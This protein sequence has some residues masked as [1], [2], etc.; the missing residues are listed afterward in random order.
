[1]MR[2]LLTGHL[3]GHHVRL[4]H[5]RI[6]DFKDLLC[7]HPGRACLRHCPLLLDVGIDPGPVAGQAHDQGAGVMLNFEDYVGETAASEDESAR[8][9][10]EVVLDD[11]V[12]HRPGFPQLGFRWSVQG[13]QPGRL[14]CMSA[15]QKKSSPSSVAS[16]SLIVCCLPLNSTAALPTTIASPTPF[17]KRSSSVSPA[18]ADWARSASK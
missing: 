11:G 15:K 9:L 5:N 13:F 14:H 16:L 18:P 3:G 4:R 7:R 6:A 8:S 12:S 10:A 17:R 2:R 1:M